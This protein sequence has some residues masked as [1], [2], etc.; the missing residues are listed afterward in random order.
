MN[1]HL[2][3][4]IFSVTNIMVLVTLIQKSSISGCVE[5]QIG[6]CEVKMQR[7][8]FQ[9]VTNPSQARLWKV[10]NFNN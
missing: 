9:F 2:V 8:E 10:S 4:L 5:I 3:F 6:F 1:Q 7:E